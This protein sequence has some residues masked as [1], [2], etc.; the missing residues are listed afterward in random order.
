MAETITFL[1]FELSFVLAFKALESQL[2]ELLLVY[3]LNHCGVLQYAAFDDRFFR[4]LGENMADDELRAMIDEF[5]HDGDG[6]SK[7]CLR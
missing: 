5:D 4:E 3:L 7:C 2:F 1:L 6:E